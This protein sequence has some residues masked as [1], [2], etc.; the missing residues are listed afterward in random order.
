ME[1]TS[2]PHIVD[3]AAHVAA[4]VTDIAHIAVHIAELSARN[5]VPVSVLH[6]LHH[7][8]VV[9]FFCNKKLFSQHMQSMASLLQLQ[10]TMLKRGNLT[11][12]Y[13][14]THQS[15]LCTVDQGGDAPET[16]RE[17]KCTTRG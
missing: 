1:D 5:N 14:P 2:V 10:H 4:Y 12:F 9:L 3:T 6:V 13:P 17:F 11:F 8:A 15:V 16:S 7:S